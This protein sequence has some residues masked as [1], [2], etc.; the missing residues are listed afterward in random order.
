MNKTLVMALAF[1]AIFS[2]IGLAAA[3]CTNN[4]QIIMRLAYETNSHGAIWNQTNYPVK[5]CYN[6]I[7]GQDYTGTNPHECVVSGGVIIDRVVSLYDVNN[8]HATID[9]SYT[10]PVCHK[11]LQDCVY[12]FH[13]ACP[14]NTYPIIN[15]TGMLNSHLSRNAMP[16]YYNYTICCAKSSGVGPEPTPPTKCQHYDNQTSYPT[17]FDS[18]GALC[19]ADTPSGLGVANDDPGCTIAD[20]SKCYCIWD[21]TKT[22]GQ[23]CNVGWDEVEGACSH[24]CVKTT[25]EGV[26]NEATGLKKVTISAKITPL[27]PSTAEDCKDITGCQGGDIDVP[28]GLV[29][30]ELPFF[31]WFNLMIAAGLITA[32]YAL[33]GRRLNR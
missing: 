5:I 22:A 7:F 15:L 4:D 6:D 13:Q 16:D 29:A 28:C 32:I 24:R 1:C 20:K 10:V 12:R 33:F 21:A 17:Y 9:T 11:G 18:T 23:R 19:N 30:L 27:P 25:K 3:A 26:C 31:G 8:S 14:A 2:T